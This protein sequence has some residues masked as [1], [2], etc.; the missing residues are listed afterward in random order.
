MISVMRSI[1]DIDG[2]SVLTVGEEYEATSLSYL[3]QDIAALQSE[4]DTLNQQYQD[5]EKQW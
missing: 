5:V 2:G 4:L 1:P 3:G